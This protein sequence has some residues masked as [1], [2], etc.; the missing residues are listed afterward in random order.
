MFIQD[1]TAI[2]KLTKPLSGLVLH[3]GEGGAAAKPCE[4]AW[5]GVPAAIG[6]QVPQITVFVSPSSLNTMRNVYARFGNKVTVHPLYLSEAELDA[7]SFKAL[8][9]ISLTDANPPLYM[10]IIMVRAYV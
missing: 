8:M 7:E 2:G 9:G 5:L 6:V 1:Y 3:Y 10:Q 4:A